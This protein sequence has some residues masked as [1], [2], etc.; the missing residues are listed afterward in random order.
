MGLSQQGQLEEGRDGLEQLICL[1]LQWSNVSDA[2]KK[3]AT[4][5]T[6][7]HYGGG[8]LIGGQHSR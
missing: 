7:F 6:K 1:M 5:C 8:Y 3:T 4:P 2:S